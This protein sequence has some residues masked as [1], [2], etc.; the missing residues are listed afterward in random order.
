[1]R[2]KYAR[3]KAVATVIVAA[4]RSSGNLDYVLRGT[5]GNDLWIHA[6]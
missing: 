5:E 3:P 1:V 4:Q 2:S 6:K